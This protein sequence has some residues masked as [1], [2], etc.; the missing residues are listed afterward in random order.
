[1]NE[2]HHEEVEAKSKIDELM[3]DLETEKQRSQ[4]YLNKLKYAQADIENLKKRFDRQLEEVRKYCTEPLVVKLLEV[5]DELELAVKHAQTSNSTET[6]VQ[7]VQMTLKK[8]EKALKDE[9]VSVI[10]ALGKRFDPCKHVAV[11]RVEKDDSDE[12]IVIEE[13][14]KGYIM[15]EKVIRPSIVKVTAKS[16][17]KP[18]TGGYEKNE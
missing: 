6:L 5:L 14:R 11:A 8:M 7:G 12:C 18:E 9:G 17:S 16:S 4:D 3:W 15:R 13:V 10:D 2:K 1:M